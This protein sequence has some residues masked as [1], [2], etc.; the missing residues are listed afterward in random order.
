MENV[1]NVE[2]TT[3]FTIPWPSGSYPFTDFRSSA[4]YFLINRPMCSLQT[5]PFSGVFNNRERFPATISQV[6]GLHGLISSL[7]KSEISLQTFGHRKG[8]GTV[9]I[10]V[11]EKRLKVKINNTVMY[12]FINPVNTLR[13]DD[14]TSEKRYS[15][16]FRCWHTR[17]PWSCRSNAE[18]ETA[19]TLNRDQV[20]YFAVWLAPFTPNFNLPIIVITYCT[21]W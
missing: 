2:K 13:I 20:T 4:L 9:C 16:S 17:N 6:S 15:R 14:I 10:F 7:F 1:L 11:S 19:G 5:L 18:R 3:V 8:D 21:Y 12:Y